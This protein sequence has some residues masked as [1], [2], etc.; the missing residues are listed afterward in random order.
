MAPKA[1]RVLQ[2]PHLTIDDAW[3]VLADSYSQEGVSDLRAD[4]NKLA[5]DYK[6]HIKGGDKDA[7]YKHRNVIKHLS[8]INNAGVWNLTLILGAVTK[9]NSKS[10]GCLLSGNEKFG[11][12][13]AE[14]AA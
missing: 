3:R 11:A 1:P 10:L 13:A 9:W 6:K 12:R 4:K 5:F 7:M 14:L 8:K 2:P